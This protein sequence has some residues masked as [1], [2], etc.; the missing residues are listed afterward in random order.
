MPSEPVAEADDRVL[1]DVARPALRKHPAWRAASTSVRR[2]APGVWATAVRGWGAARRALEPID[3]G[4][5]AAVAAW[6]ARQQRAALEQVDHVLHFAGFARSGHSVI[7]SL[8]NAHPDMVVAHR[9]RLMRYANAGVRGRPL[10]AMPLVADRRFEARGRVGSKRYDYT[11]PGQWQ[12]R[13]RRL[14]V[15]GDS[16][17]ASGTLILRPDAFATL[18]TRLDRP[19]KVISVVRNPFDNIA[20][21][22]R[23]NRMTLDEAADEY[24]DRAR[25]IVGMTALVPA[26]SWLEVRQEDVIADPHGSLRSMCAFLGVDAPDDYLD[27]CAAVLFSRPNRSRTTVEWPESTIAAI[28]DRAAAIPFLAGY[29]F[30]DG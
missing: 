9:A 30:A 25:T 19:V 28:E 7:A 21:L 11:V 18:L 1:A 22:S 2:R 27:A 16:D 14:M 20:T 26:S 15:V 29:R 13:F 5:D 8:L 24:F 6:T 12:G 3:I 17:S 10:L 23:R 4:R